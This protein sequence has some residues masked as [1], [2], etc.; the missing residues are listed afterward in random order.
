MILDGCSFVDII[1]SANFC[2]SFVS[3]WLSSRHI[4]PDKAQSLCMC[5][6]TKDSSLGG[7][8]AE[9]RHKRL[10]GQIFPFFST[11]LYPLLLREVVSQQ[12]NVP[13]ERFVAVQGDVNKN[14]G[15]LVRRASCSFILVTDRSCGAVR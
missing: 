10:I 14:R 13:E 12:E 9:E 7:K 4:M 2:G 6:E 1:I 5:E 3:L 8:G 11:I 15:H